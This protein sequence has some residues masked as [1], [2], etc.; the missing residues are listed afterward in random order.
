MENNLANS[1]LNNDYNNQPNQNQALKNELIEFG[2]MDEHIDLALK[3]TS[4]KQE[5]IDLYK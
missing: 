2:F 5:A 3:M 4:E 1:K